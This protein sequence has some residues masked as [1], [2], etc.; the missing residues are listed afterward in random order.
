[1]GKLLGIVRII[2]STPKLSEEDIKSRAFLQAEVGIHRMDL[3]REDAQVHDIS[4][5]LTGTVYVIANSRKNKGKVLK[6]NILKDIVQRGLM[7][8]LKGSKKRIDK[9]LTKKM[10]QLHCLMMI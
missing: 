8:E 9:P 5:S 10:R 3:P 1:M 4:I 2:K 7:Q 6:E